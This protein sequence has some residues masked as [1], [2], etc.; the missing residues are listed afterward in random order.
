VPAI[1]AILFAVAAG[2]AVIVIATILV[3][4]GVHHEERNRTLTRQ[5][6]PTTAA[7]LARR[8]LRTPVD[9]SPGQQ[10]ERAADHNARSR[11][12]HCH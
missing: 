11:H 7:I 12:G 3:I 9:R 6:P 1:E 4:I 10:E 8:V 2:F 5:H